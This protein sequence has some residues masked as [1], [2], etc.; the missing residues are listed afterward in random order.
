MANKLTT[1][2]YIVKR[3]RDCGY[4]TYKLFTEYSDV[5]PRMWTIMID[6]GVSSVLCTCYVD[7]PLLDETYLELFDG[8]QFI[9][10]RLKI[11]TDSF[12]VF[13][14]YLVEC[15]INNKAPKYPS[16]KLINNN[17]KD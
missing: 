1:L 11:K 5:D 13:I 16:E 4:Y 2:G 10:G 14:E 8:G 7:D 15:G 6:P 9:P 17:V 3:L 12:E